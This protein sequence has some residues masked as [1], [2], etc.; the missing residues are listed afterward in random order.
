MTLAGRPGTTERLFVAALLPPAW[1]AEVTRFQHHLRSQG[2]ELRDVSRAAVH[3]TLK[4]LG[5]T[6]LDRRPAIEAALAEVAERTTSFEIGLG[7]PGWFDSE[8]RPRTIWLGLHD[9]DGRLAKLA[10][11]LQWS[12]RAAGVAAER[13]PFR[14][15][16]TVARVP[17]RLPAAE[18]R[19][20]VPSL[21][22]YQP[23]PVGPHQIEHFALMRSLLRPEGALYTVLRSFAFSGRG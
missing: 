9:A 20:I 4:F 6:P 16:L 8:V 19:R 23:A 2:L 21:R 15:H 10:T 17:E 3:L 14:A 18:A 7:E 1:L 22:R 5:D 12:L 11:S 13:R